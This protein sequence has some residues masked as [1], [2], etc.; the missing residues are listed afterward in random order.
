M[1]APATLEL[2]AEISIGL[3][4]FAGVV[5]ALGRSKLAIQVRSFRT[6]AL[7]LNSGTALFGSLLP[8]ILLNAG[9]SVPTV[10]I[11]SSIALALIMAFSLAWV[12]SQTRNLMSQAGVPSA[13]TILIIVFASFVAFALLYSSFFANG[14]LPRIYP[15][16]V[17]WSLSL[18]VFHFCMLVISIELPGESS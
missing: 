10:W 14:F 4:G 17:F 13:V 18:G 3:I 15:A 6:R 7:V 16:A 11:T 9:L 12:T 8:L 5:T 2:L 1:E